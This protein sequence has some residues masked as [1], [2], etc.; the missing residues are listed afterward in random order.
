[1]KIISPVGSPVQSYLIAEYI[2]EKEKEYEV[3]VF[4]FVE[5]KAASGGYLVASTSASSY[6]LIFLSMFSSMTKLLDMLGNES[7]VDIDTAEL[8]KSG[9]NLLTASTGV[10]EMYIIKNSLGELHL[11][12]IKYTVLEDKV[13]ELIDE[14]KFKLVQI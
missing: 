8:Q 11:A 9:V 12:F 6:F 1:M 13:G 3:P 10:K 2:R 14:T 5:D 4:C 7:K